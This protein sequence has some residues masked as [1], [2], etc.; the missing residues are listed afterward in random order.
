MEGL[1]LTMNTLVRMLI[2]P[3]MVAAHI[4][5]FL[6]SARAGDNLLRVVERQVR[7]NSFSRLSMN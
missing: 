4:P 1:A 2:F 6:R 3:I 7:R 5:P